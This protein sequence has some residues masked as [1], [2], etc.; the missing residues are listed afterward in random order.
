V[1]ECHDL[2]DD[3]PTA[4]SPQLEAVGAQCHDPY[5]SS[6]VT[7]AAHTSPA[8]ECHLINGHSGPVRLVRV[9][10][11]LDWTSAAR[12]GDLMRHDCGDR[13]VIVDLSS[14]ESDGAGTGSLLAA[15]AHAEEI[16]QQL[17]FVVNDPLELE[18]LAYV[19]LDQVMPIVASVPAALAW[20]ATHSVSAD[21]VGT[22]K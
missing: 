12:F 4:S 19:G 20:L 2:Y 17:V 8:H 5:P 15:A 13:E 9:T 10:G 22:R 21:A 6:P 11:H 7:G 18:V 16:G 1:S 3:V 14:T